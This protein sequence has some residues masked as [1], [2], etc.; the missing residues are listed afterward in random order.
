MID[1]NAYSWCDDIWMT[2]DNEETVAAKVSVIFHIVDNKKKIFVF[3]DSIRL[4]SGFR[5]GHGLVNRH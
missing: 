2:F 4:R 3:S 5:W 1:G